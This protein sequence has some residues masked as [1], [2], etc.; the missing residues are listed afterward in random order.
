[1]SMRTRFIALTVVTAGLAGG[2]YYVGE[3]SPPPPPARG[4]RQAAVPVVVAPAEIKTIPITFNTIATVEALLTVA[5][6]SRVDGQIVAA[7]FAEGQAVRK[8]DLLFKIDPRPLEASLKMVEAT[9]ARDQAQLANVK[10]N[11]ERYSSL[12]DKGFATRQQLDETTAQVAMLEASLR[13]AAAAI[14]LAK[15]QLEYTD[16]R[17]PVDG[18]AGAQLI[19]PGNLVKA[20]DT[21]PLVIIKQVRPI[22]VAFSVPESIL[23][24]VRGERAAGRIATTVTIPGDRGSPLTGELSFVDN[25]V[26]A[27]TG[28]IKMKATFSNS[29]DRLTPGQFVNAV[30]TVATLENVVVV[31]TQAVETGQKGPYVYVVGGDNLAQFRPVVTGPAVNGVTVIQSGVAPGE[32]VVTDGQLRLVAGIAVN[33]RTDS[34][35]TSTAAGR[36]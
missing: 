7:R 3:S 34:A 5:I 10:R 14:D 8:N 11:L 12:S 29:D 28:T 19:S 1:M 26:D 35:T 16:I 22:Y 4:G 18:V 13:S 21:N 36:E 32:Q 30:L 33:T 15:L 27:S 17:S 25:A 23:P 9:L 2:Y 24:Q 6:K 20:N 31:P